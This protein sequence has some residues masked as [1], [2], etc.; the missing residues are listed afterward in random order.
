MANK[1]FLSLLMQICRMMLFDTIH[2]CGQ[3]TSYFRPIGSTQ[4]ELMGP[5]AEV[6]EAM[7]AKMN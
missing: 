3:L 2:H 1:D 4:P 6:E 5:T 7:M